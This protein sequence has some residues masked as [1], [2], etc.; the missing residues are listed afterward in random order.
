[1]DNTE[2]SAMGMDALG[3]DLALEPEQAEQVTGGVRFSCSACHH[4]HAQS[5]PKCLPACPH[6]TS[7]HG[8]GGASTNVTNVY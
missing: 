8:T 7:I 6:G 5:D 4:V 2:Q 1:M 3:E